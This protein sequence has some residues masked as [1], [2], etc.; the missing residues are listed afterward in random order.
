MK[1]VT[2]FL[3]GFT[4]SGVWIALNTFLYGANIIYLI[5]KDHP[6][7][8]ERLA[9][10][11]I[12]AVAAIATVISSAIVLITRSDKRKISGKELSLQCFAGALM[13]VPQR[14]MM[15]PFVIMLLNKR[16]INPVQSVVITALIWLAGMIFQS[17]LMTKNFGIKAIVSEML[18]SLVFSLGIGYAFYVSGCIFVPMAFHVLERVLS[19]AAF[20]G[21]T[22]ISRII[23]CSI[24]TDKLFI[25]IKR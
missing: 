21:K 10:I 12:W 4:L 3:L 17:A 1:A 13:E 11:K 6:F 5:T 20:I 25:V 22:F 2:V 9:D 23:N 8:F 24:K 19:N 15:M 18:P 14:A 7:H 16:G